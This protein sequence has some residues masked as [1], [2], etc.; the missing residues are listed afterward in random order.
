MNLNSFY[1]VLSNFHSKYRNS[2]SKNNY[3]PKFINNFLIFYTIF[4]CFFAVA[5]VNDQTIYVLYKNIHLP[6]FFKIYF[7]HIFPA[8]KM[9]SLFYSRFYFAFCNK[10]QK[11]AF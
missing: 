4:S 10:Y 3:Y 7:S 2:K 1:F 11:T 8:F 5:L 9:L 6:E